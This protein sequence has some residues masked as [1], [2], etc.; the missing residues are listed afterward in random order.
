MCDER[1]LLLHVARAL[2]DHEGDLD[3][4]VELE[5]ALGDHHVVVGTDDAVGE[6]V[7]EDGLLGNLR[8]GLLGVVDVV[9]AH[10]DEVVHVADRGAQAHALRRRRQRL[11]VE[12]AQ[13]VE[14]GVAQRLAGDVLHVRRQIANDALGVDKAGLLGAGRAKS[15][16]LHGGSLLETILGRAPSSKP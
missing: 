10:G 3:L 6:L 4:V 2:A 9:E 1:V 5:R 13:L 15:N 7:E 14:A 11:G 8:A 16:K 12:L